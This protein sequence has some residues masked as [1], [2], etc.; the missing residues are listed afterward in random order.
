MLTE[1]DVRLNDIL[2]INLIIKG[3]YRQIPL[4]CIGPFIKTQTTN[5]YH[6]LFYMCK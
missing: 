5:L 2:N 6:L 3:K 4:V 1:P